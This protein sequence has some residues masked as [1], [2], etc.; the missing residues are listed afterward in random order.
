M[1]ED[2]AGAAP[3]KTDEDLELEL[4]PDPEIDTDD[5]DTLRDKLNKA[6]E[7]KRQLHSRAKK[8]EDELKKLKGSPNPVSPANQPAKKEETNTSTTTVDVD[9][10]ILKSQGMSDE[11][12]KELKAVAQVRGVSLIDAQ[13]DPI[14]VAVK[15]KFE[16]DQKK[17][18]ASLP[19]SRG[20]GGA[21]SK[22]DFTTP[23][24]S[25][26]EHKQLAKEA[27]EK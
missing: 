1:A 24:L 8:A 11:L 6:D 21:K 5:A 9:E 2:N 25:R 16:K 17:E 19:A 14:F 18:D 26:D 23:N 15:E 20:S 4:A 10:R 12:L 3:T 27:L 22:K 7:A 13:K